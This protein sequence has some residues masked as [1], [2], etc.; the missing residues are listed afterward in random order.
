MKLIGEHWSGRPGR[1]LV[2][3]HRR[4]GDVVGHGV[5]GAGVAALGL[6][7]AS[8][9]HARGNARDHRAGAGHAADGHVVGRAA[10]GHHRRGCAGRA[11][12]GHIAGAK[13]VT[14]SLK[15]TVKLIGE[16]L[17]GSACPAAWLMVTVGAVTS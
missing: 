12:Q 3:R 11:A 6:P 10:A 1:R 4:S 9:G 17:V 7:A 2:D 13:S 8:V 14:G 15:T 5:V 16:A